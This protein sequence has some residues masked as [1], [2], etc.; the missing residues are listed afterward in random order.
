M[1]KRI[2]V[3]YFASLREEAGRQKETVST[4][5]KTVGDFYKEL[6]TRYKFRLSVDML[7]AAVNDEFASWKTVLKTNDQVVF[8]P[9]VA[10]G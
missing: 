8:I 9:P 1:K 5:A 7:R 2:H 6:Q 4:S 3:E 10:G